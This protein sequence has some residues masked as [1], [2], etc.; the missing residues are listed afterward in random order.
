VSLPPKYAV[1]GEI[2]PDS[3]LDADQP[4]WGQKFLNDEDVM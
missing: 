3:L 4:D 1:G 2:D